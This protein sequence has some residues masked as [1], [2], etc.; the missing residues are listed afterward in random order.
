[1]K[2][3]ILIGLNRYDFD[4]S[5]NHVAENYLL[6][7]G[8]E[9]SF[10]EKEGDHMRKP[11]MIERIGDADACI[12]YGYLD[13]D[14]LAAAKKLKIMTIMAVGFDT[15]DV[16]AC[17]EHN[18]RVTIA[19]CPE[20]AHGVAEVA[21]T[22]MLASNY[23]VIKRHHETTAG[24]FH[25]Y[26]GEQ[27]YGKTLGIVGFGWIG[28]R[29]ARLVMPYGM[30]VLAYDPYP[31]PQAAFAL[32]AEYVSLDEL[33]KES[34]FVSVHIPGT[35]ENYHL[36][37][38]ATFAKMKQGAQFINTSRGV[39]VDEDALYRALTS[40]HL[41]GAALDV[42]EN[43]GEGKMHPLYQLENFCVLPHTGGHNL[44]ARNAMIMRCAK[45]SWNFS[46]ARSRRINFGSRMEE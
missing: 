12:H 27:M 6:E 20:H 43:E 21:M 22:L 44:R 45:I 8:F 26:V 15:T 37:N 1:M 3:K 38:D 13:H 36:F 24:H 10:F 16:A 19:R 34:D 40:G 31:N 41:K 17:K 9:L 30:R 42:M 35:P 5:N 28:Q 14:V 23:D 33:L 46:K 32:D 4:P 39:N 2:R 25:Q 11:E 7:H 29:L 18:V